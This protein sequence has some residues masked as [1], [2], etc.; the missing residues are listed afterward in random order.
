[1]ALKPGH[2]A[3]STGE[4]RSVLYF[5][6]PCSSTQTLLVSPNE[7]YWG[8]PSRVGTPWFQILGDLDLSKFLMS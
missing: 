1:M 8:P 5:T 7:E 3:E 2:H 6:F 4:L